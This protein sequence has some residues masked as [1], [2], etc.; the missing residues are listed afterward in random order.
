MA[1]YDQPGVGKRAASGHALP[2]DD[3]DLAPVLEQVICAAD[4]DDAGADYEDVYF[5]QLAS[6]VTSPCR[7]SG[8]GPTAKEVYSSL[9][10]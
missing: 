4:A 3:R 10:V 9:A 1:G 6:Q 8:C 2:V 5:P 7:S